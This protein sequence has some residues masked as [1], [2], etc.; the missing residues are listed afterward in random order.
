[1]RETDGSD[2]HNRT[3][4]WMAAL[5]YCLCRRRALGSGHGPAQCLAN[6][7]FDV[8]DARLANRWRRRRS[9]ARHRRGGGDR[10]VVRLWLFPGGPFF[11]RLRLSGRCTDIRL[12]TAVFRDP[13]AGWA[14]RI[15]PLPP[16]PVP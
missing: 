12:A 3:V 10:L 6:P 1:R 5:A 9:L 7:V 4:I 2:L 15:P 13:S 14:R 8:S 16:R 11:G